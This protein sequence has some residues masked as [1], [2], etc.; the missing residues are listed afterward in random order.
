MDLQISLPTFPQIARATGVQGLAGGQAVDLLSEGAGASVDEVGLRFIHEH[1]TGAL[2]EAAVV[3][4]ALLGG[5]DEDAISRLRRYARAVGLA[6]QIIDDILDVTASSEQLGKTA[7]KDLASEKT[8]Y[9]SLL[10]L[11]GSR[12]AADELILEAKDQLRAFDLES[13][14]PL[15]ALAEYIRVRTS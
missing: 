13:A 5:G 11:E 6:F 2:L 4:G 1:K 3:S 15:L 9:P 12:K 10:G 14:A 7:G 8:T